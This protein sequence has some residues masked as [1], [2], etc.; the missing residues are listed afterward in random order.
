LSISRSARPYSAAED[1]VL[2]N[3]V[4]RGLA[5]KQI[6]GEFDQLFAK[7][8]LRSLQLHWSRNLKLTALPTRSSKRKRSSL[9]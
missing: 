4:A 1:E 9:S 3:L 8:T 5:W 2:K 6:E 7:R